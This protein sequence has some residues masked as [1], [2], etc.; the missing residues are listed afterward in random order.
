MI[1]GIRQTW[2]ERIRERR[3]AM[4][5]AELAR[6]VGRT[7]GMISRIEQGTVAVTDELKLRIAQALDVSVG[8]LFGW[9]VVD[10]PGCEGHSL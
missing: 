1:D 7:Q 3:G 8:E 6:R 2:G 10:A 5:Q 9:P 4:T